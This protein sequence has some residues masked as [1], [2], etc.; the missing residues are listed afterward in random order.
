MNA[1][2]ADLQGKY[3]FCWSTCSLEHLGSIANG[4]N[5]IEESLKTLKPGGVAVHTTEWNLDDDGPT[6]DH[7]GCVL[8]QR[9]HFEAF[10]ARMKQKGFELPDIDFSKGEQIF[11]GLVD[12]PPFGA[13]TDAVAHLRLSVSGFR[14]TSF[15]LIIRKPIA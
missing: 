6:Q 9:R 7:C 12:L 5:F 8:F 15:G 1:I 10:A 14:C 13:H 2:P 3:D 11:D 4:L